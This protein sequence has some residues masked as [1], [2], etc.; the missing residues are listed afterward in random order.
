MLYF[1]LT[2]SLWKEILPEEFS[3]LQKA[4]KEVD[5]FAKPPSPLNWCSLSPRSRH[6]HARLP[7]PAWRTRPTTIK[8]SY[9]GIITAIDSDMLIFLLKSL[10]AFRCT[11]ELV[12][13]RIP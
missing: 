13:T 5:Y 12:L 9:R 4:A 11:E 6:S 8:H 10:A 2:R 3:F 1:H 7:N